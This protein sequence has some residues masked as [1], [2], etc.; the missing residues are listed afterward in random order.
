MWGAASYE[1]AKAVKMAADGVPDLSRVRSSVEVSL[2][3]GSPSRCIFSL[4]VLHSSCGQPN[5]MVLPLLL[6][7]IID[8]MVLVPRQRGAPGSLTS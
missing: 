1:P 6:D 2:R 5:T 8:E 4:K 3:I 7:R